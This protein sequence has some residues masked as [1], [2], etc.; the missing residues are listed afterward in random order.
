MATKTQTPTNGKATAADVA[1][2]TPATLK[3]P[4]P[5]ARRIIAKAQAV[6]D[7]RAELDELVMLARELAG[8]SDRAQMRPL[9]G[10]RLEW[11][12]PAAKPAPAEE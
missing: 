5:L 10:D 6:D 3:V 9:P 4:E 2:S 1:A 12:E 8:A 11:V 7:A